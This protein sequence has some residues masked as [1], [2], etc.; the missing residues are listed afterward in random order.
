MK[1]TVSQ[2]SLSD[3]L[4]TVLKGVGGTSTLPIL[5]GVLIKAGDGVL[6]LHTTNGD[7]SIKHRITARVD[8]PGEAVV[9]CKLFS[10][11]T[12]ALPDAPVSF[13]VVERQAVISCAKS[14]FRLNMLD[15]NDFPE[16]P[17]LA[18]ESSVDLPANT[19]AE[20]V[21]R[22]WRVASRD[23]T[24]GVLTGVFMTVENNTVRLVS[25]DSYRL[26]ICDT[27]VETSSLEDPFEA[28]IPSEALNDALSIMGDAPTITVGVTDGQII[29]ETGTTFY[30]SRRVKGQFPNYRGLIPSSCV[31]SAKL[32]TAAFSSAVKRVAAIGAGSPTLRFDIDAEA[33]V[34]KL[35]LVS[36]D[37]GYASETLDIEVEG[38]SGFSGFNCHYVMDFFNMAGHDKELTFEI[39]DYGRPAIFKTFGKINYLYLVMPIRLSE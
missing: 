21:S 1:F 17:T 5:N 35:T 24:R 23:R 16:F 18:V 39:Q 11:I 30:V 25:T 12:K 37:Q 28:I 7:I 4:T 33:G 34:L 31:M 8:E 27:Q 9:P 38:K 13:E 26:A 6:E 10:N 29:F 19:L 32:D 36:N 20:M 2:D 15:P 3:A 14:S 22:V